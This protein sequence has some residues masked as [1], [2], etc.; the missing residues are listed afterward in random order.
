ML[1]ITL[2]INNGHLG[3]VGARN[4]LLQGGQSC[5]GPIVE[6]QMRTDS[7]GYGF[8]NTL[9][10][11]VVGRIRGIF[12]LS[13]SATGQSDHKEK[14]NQ[15]MCCQASMQCCHQILYSNP[16]SK[17]RRK[18]PQ[19]AIVIAKLYRTKSAKQN[20]QLGRFHVEK[21]NLEFPNYLYIYGLPK[22]S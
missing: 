6:V 3:S 17:T 19:I 18:S 22:I 4:L 20:V 11:E 1:C 14:S 2:Y 7:I 16:S 5:L 12:V 8:P 10:N 13:F 9:F 21:S 15:L